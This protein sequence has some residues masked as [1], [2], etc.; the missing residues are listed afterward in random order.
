[1][2]AAAPSPQNQDQQWSFARVLRLLGKES[3][4]IIIITALAKAADIFNFIHKLSDADLSAPYLRAGV[5]VMLVAIHAGCGVVFYRQAVRRIHWRRPLVAGG[6]TII[7]AG[8]LWRTI[9]LVNDHL[10][11]RPR[12]PSIA[13]LENRWTQQL[14]DTQ[15]DTGASGGFGTVQAGHRP[16]DAWTSAQALNA[17][18]RGRYHSGRAAEI[19]KAFAYIDRGQ[20]NLGAG[21]SGWVAQSGDKWPRTEI[22]AWVALAYLVGLRSGDVWDPTEAPKIC[23]RV[24][25]L[26]ADIAG[27]QN[28]AT[29]GGWGPTTLNLPNSD[30]T[31]ST[32]LVLWSLLEGRRTEPVASSI[33]TR[34]DNNIRNG[35]AALLLVPHDGGWV[36][37][38]GSSE[39][40][41]GLTFQALYVLSIAADDPR[42]FKTNDFEEF[43]SLRQTFVTDMVV[44]PAAYQMLE[45]TSGDDQTVRL[46]DG[47]NIQEPFYV[48]FFPFPWSLALLH[49][50]AHEPGLPHRLQSKASE[51]ASQLEQQ[52][53]SAEAIAYF[54]KVDTYELA[55]NLIGLESGDAK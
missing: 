17:I 26:L 12:Q 15:T 48:T 27:R 22:T 5:V 19:K 8:F 34:F 37:S 38:L 31:Y 45:R 20:V 33:G 10:P 41:R 42:L 1:M 51:L 43:E 32:V 55:E 11:S 54:R 13:D 3:P 14:F 21:G 23:D 39:T 6:I 28:S 44:A 7:M 4:I 24:I 9:P 25:K 18:L 30:R 49:H 47:S 29:G 52:V 50:M 16:P 53:R 35:I 2:A 36:A 46:P 40:H